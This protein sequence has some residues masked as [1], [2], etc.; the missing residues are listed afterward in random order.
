MCG[1]S[2][3]AIEITRQTKTEAH[4]LRALTLSQDLG[5]VRL[6]FIQVLK[7]GYHGQVSS[8]SAPESKPYT[9]TYNAVVVTIF[10]WSAYVLSA[11][12][13][14]MGFVLRSC[15]SLVLL[16]RCESDIHRLVLLLLSDVGKL[17]DSGGEGPSLR[18][19]RSKKVRGNMPH[20]F[21]AL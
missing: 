6:P 1:K 5:C 11:T 20:F 19:L 4:R 18:V 15:V 7:A 16:S 2:S 21:F 8:Q 10:G 12:S 13:Q 14:I 9:I 3:L 17:G